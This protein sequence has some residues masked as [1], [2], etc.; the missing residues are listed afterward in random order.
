[1]R[2]RNIIILII[3]FILV[4]GLGIGLGFYIEK[5][6][7]NPR[8]SIPGVFSR[9]LSFFVQKGVDQEEDLLYYD[10][11]LSDFIV[12][13]SEKTKIKVE[14]VVDKITR[15][16]DGDSH[17]ILSTPFVP[18]LALVTETIP[19]VPLPLPQAGDRIKIWGI[20]RFDILHN[21]WEIHPVVGWEKVAK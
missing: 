14:G 16:P 19:E 3:V 10:T 20:T 1:M 7:V 15:E 5:Q 4:F 2:K 11:N 17:I 8:A 12:N 6:N 21:W 18:L 13:G 9:V